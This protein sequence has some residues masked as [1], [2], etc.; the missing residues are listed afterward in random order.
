[1]EPYDFLRFSRKPMNKLVHSVLVVDGWVPCGVLEGVHVDGILR[2]VSGG[3][4]RRR[5]RASH[6]FHV[7]LLAANERVSVFVSRF[8]VRFLNACTVTLAIVAVKRLVSVHADDVGTGRMRF[9]L[10]MHMF[11][12]AAALTR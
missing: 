2:R 9:M 12:V 4:R 5:S 11:L 1:M 3:K 6:L 8:C 7:H 10:K